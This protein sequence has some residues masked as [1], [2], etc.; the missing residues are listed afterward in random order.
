MST[1]G[2]G[3]MISSLFVTLEGNSYG[4]LVS[5]FWPMTLIG[6]I[7]LIFAGWLFKHRMY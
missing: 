4:D 6:L 5:Q 1:V 2:I 3:L 7:S